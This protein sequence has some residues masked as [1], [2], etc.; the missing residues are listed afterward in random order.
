MLKKTMACLSIATLIFTMTENMAQAQ[1]A[2]PLISNPVQLVDMAAR[3]APAGVKV[4]FT[5]EV[6]AIGHLKDRIILNSEEDY[7][8][9]KNISV[10][11][12]PTAEAELVHTLGND[13]DPLIKGHRI[14]VQGTIKR[15]T[16]WFFEKGV[17]T[18]KYYYQ[19]HILVKNADQIKEIK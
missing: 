4:N 5:M 18:D 12:Y 17:K 9:P 19:T 6:K 7:R 10:D 1:D 11:V 15:V 16:V 13:L 14:R 2:E 3:A 8:D